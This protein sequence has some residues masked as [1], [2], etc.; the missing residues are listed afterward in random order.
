MQ[1][2]G[3]G[4]ETPKI[5]PRDT[6]RPFLV[7]PVTQM[8]NNSYRRENDQIT[9]YNLENHLA[10]DKLFNAQLVEMGRWKEGDIKGSRKGKKLLNNFDCVLFS[11]LYLKMVTQRNDAILNVVA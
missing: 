9:I 3:Q 1:K 8:N 5:T 10:Y 7:D 4:L 11:A 6:E 2:V